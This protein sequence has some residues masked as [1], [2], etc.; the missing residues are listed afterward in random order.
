MKLSQINGTLDLLKES[1]LVA[2]NELVSHIM[3][4]LGKIEYE[5]MT[6]K[7]STYNVRVHVY[8]KIDKEK[9][10]DYMY[11]NEFI[12]LSYNGNKNRIYGKQ[13]DGCLY[14]SVSLEDV[15]MI[16]FKFSGKLPNIFDNV[17]V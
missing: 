2:I 5:I 6:D 10:K 8:D 17:I 14:L 15:T 11:A 4:S 7:N 13:F 3:S 16:D 12:D 1:Y 9:I